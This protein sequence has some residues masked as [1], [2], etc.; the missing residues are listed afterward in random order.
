MKDSRQLQRDARNAQVRTRRAN[1]R[2]T[3]AQQERRKRDALKRRMI[4]H[5]G[6]ACTRCKRTLEDF[7]HP[8]AFD[9]H[10]RDP[11]EKRF[12]VC[13]N[14]TRSW[15][16]LEAELQKCDLMCACC[17]RIIEAIAA[18]D[19]AGLTVDCVPAAGLRGGRPP[20]SAEQAIENEED[21]RARDAIRAATLYTERREAERRAR[22]AMRRDQI[23]LFELEAEDDGCFEAERAA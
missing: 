15:A 23:L 16:V 12:N 3:I 14:Y 7:G 11:A 22:E 19:V 21:E 2:D 6:S 9:F 13:G 17:H 18:D 5:R 1:R 20:K 4:A 10:H 8:A